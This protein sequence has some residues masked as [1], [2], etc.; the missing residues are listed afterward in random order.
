MDSLPTSDTRRVG[1]VARDLLDRI[2]DRWSALVIYALHEKPARFS[3]L[4]DQIDALGPKLLSRT[5][6]SHKMLA[7]TLKGLRR[8]GLIRRGE[9]GGH[10]EYGLTPLGLSFWEPMMAVHDWTATHLDQIEEAR[11]A[12]DTAEQDG[13]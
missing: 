8:D 6:I 10:A 11:R 3:E 12:F 5:E 1:L 9:A 2:G 4:K 13:T 7:E